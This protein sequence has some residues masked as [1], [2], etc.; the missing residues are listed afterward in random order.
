[1]YSRFI[2]RRIQSVQ[3]Q[4]TLL[5]NNSTVNLSDVGS[6]IKRY[7]YKLPVSYS[8]IQVEESWRWF[9]RI[10]I[11][12]PRKPQIDGHLSKAWTRAC[13]WQSMH[14]M[15]WYKVVVVKWKVNISGQQFE[16]K[17]VFNLKNMKKSKQKD[18]KSIQNKLL[19]FIHQMAIILG[20]LLCTWVPLDES[21]SK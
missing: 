1:M 10:T 18:E 17:N 7:A 15:N 8:A 3:W 4:N 2:M 16:S 12:N 14:L 5:D 20:R 21:K 11:G 9:D 19:A 13:H 6:W